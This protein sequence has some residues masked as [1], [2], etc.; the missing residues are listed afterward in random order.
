[1]KDKVTIVVVLRSGGDFAFRDVELIARHI[2]G[3]WQSEV[4]PRIICLWD[5]AT[6][7][8]DLGNIEILP[9]KTDLK[10]TWSRMV[11]YS[12]EMEP[13][14]P[15]LYVDLDTAIIRSLE[16]IIKLIPDQSKFITLEDFWQ[17]GKLATGLVWFPAQSKSTAKV[18]SDWKKNPQGGS[19][20]DNF[21]RGSVAPDLFF[22]QFTTSIYDF[23]PKNAPLL[24]GIPEDANIICFHGKPRIFQLAEA[25]MSVEWV[26]DY[27][28]MDFTGVQG[29]KK[30]TVIIPYNIDRGWLKEAVNSVPKDVQLLISQGDGNWPANFNK[31]L[32]LAEGDYI[33]FL[34]EDDMLTPNCIVDSVRALEEQK[35]DF[36]HG[37]ALQLSMRTGN[38][39]LYQPQM[40][41][42][43]VQALMHKNYL[44]SATLMYRKEIFQRLGGFDET[45]NSQE[46][47]EFNLRCLKAGFKLGYCNST[48]AVYRRHPAQKVRMLS[49][50]EKTQE[51]DL[52]NQ[53]YA[54]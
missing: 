23:K 3:K 44:H 47:Y 46:E 17:P 31:V 9:L 37:N 30:V 50:K 29:K 43:N 5:K 8:Y 35:V 40:H 48:L 49:K 7:E 19:R 16:N 24:T 39:T 21:L 10:G 41:Y 1:M 20:M 14:K 28:G 15:F 26:K 45:L 18:W 54:E 12:S 25:S 22:Q 27:V 52:V 11:L 33:K 2:N 53:K 32:H 36:I 6:E 38:K 4:R 34:H 51:K 42:P 13:Y